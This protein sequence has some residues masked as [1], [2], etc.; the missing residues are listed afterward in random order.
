MNEV[1]VKVFQLQVEQGFLQC[2]VHVLRLVHGIP[3]L[4]GNP[5][6]V[7]LHPALIHGVAQGAA[8]FGLVAINCGAVEVAVA[9]FD[10]F[11]YGFVQLAFLGFPGT[12]P[13]GRNMIFS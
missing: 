3:Q 4:G 8:H 6:L 9:N 11:D 10:G 2:G 5:E 1:Q 7:A 12:Q 13:E